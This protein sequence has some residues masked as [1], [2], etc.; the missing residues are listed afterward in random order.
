MVF[1]ADLYQNGKI[2]NEK[3][4]GLSKGK[5]IILPSTY[6]DGRGK[7]Q[8]LF[9]DAMAVIRLNR[10]FFFGWDDS[11]IVSVNNASGFFLSGILTI[12]ENL[13]KSSRLAVI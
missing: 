6:K 1:R 3:D 4:S 11:P 12:K 10:I 2:A 13:L 9:Q 7:L 5:R 8:Q